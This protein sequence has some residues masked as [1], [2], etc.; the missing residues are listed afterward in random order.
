M[1]ELLFRQPMR[2]PALLI[3]LIAF[4]GILI[5]AGCN[6]DKTPPVVTIIQPLDNA[7]LGGVIGIKA[8]ASD[9]RSTPVVDFYVDGNYLATDSTGA[10][11]VYSASWDASAL[12]TGST[13][14]I[15]AT[16]VDAA[17]NIGTSS[18]ITV[19]IGIPAG[20]TNHSGAITSRETWDPRG[21]PHVV[22]GDLN[23]TNV[24]L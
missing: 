7:T 12:D 16:A 10:D 3:T 23:I 13:H 21:N 24:A 18:E 2:K 4:F 9:D 14:K 17:G 22:T 8:Q 5:F 11:S 20:P 19:T 6:P 15:K 1:S